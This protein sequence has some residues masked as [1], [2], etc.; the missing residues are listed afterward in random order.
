MNCSLKG[1]RNRILFTIG[2]SWRLSHSTLFPSFVIVGVFDQQEQVGNENIKMETKRKR[3]WKSSRIPVSF[4]KMFLTILAGFGQKEHCDASHKLWNVLLFPTNILWESGFKLY[5]S[6][7]LP[8]ITS[9]FLYFVI[10]G[11]SEC[12]L[13]KSCCSVSSSQL[14]YCVTSN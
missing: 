12:I 1:S 13:T 8:K 3:E 10:V 4:L 2:A 14:I 11:I 9:T 5:S 7:H 6:Q